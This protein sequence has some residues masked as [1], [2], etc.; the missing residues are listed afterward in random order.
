MAGFILLPIRIAFPTR[1][2]EKGAW[3]RIKGYQT[4]LT[5]RAKLNLHTF[6][7]PGFTPFFPNAQAHLW[8]HFFVQVAEGD[9]QPS[10]SRR[11][12]WE[13]LLCAPGDKH[14]VPMN[15]QGKVLC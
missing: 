8:P 14:L 12:P 10:H 13:R 11:H 1:C 3:S 2:C 5:S 6:F 7:L 15:R 4:V 9:R